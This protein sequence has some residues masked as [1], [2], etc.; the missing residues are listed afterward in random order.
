MMTR[1]PTITC[2]KIFPN[3]NNLFFGYIAAKIQHDCMITRTSS[4][5]LLNY[6]GKKIEVWVEF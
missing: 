2:L 5:Q 4:P 1:W 6:I 3:I